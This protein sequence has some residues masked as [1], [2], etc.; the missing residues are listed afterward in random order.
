M[1]LSDEKILHLQLG[2]STSLG[3]HIL[4]MCGSQQCRAS[5]T[6]KVAGEPPEGSQPSHP[7]VA[8]PSQDPSITYASWKFLERDASKR[9][10]IWQAGFGRAAERIS[11]DHVFLTDGGVKVRSKDSKASQ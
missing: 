7:I 11:N 1:E 9:V 8:L 2:L 5:L 4:R 10:A 3:G 6:P